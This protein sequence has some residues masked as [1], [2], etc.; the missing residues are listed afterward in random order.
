VLDESEFELKWGIWVKTKERRYAPSTYKIVN[1]IR[2]IPSG[3]VD[4]Y[5]RVAQRA[6]LYKGA[7]QVVRILST[8][9]D[10][11]KLPWH[12]VLNKQGML[13]LKGESFQVQE[14]LLK[15]EGVVIE[16]GV[17]DLTIFLYKDKHD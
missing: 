10:L 1:A 7:R 16:H 13:A 5:G 8:L 11:E 4:T 15:S 9:G 2:E 3:K 6:G 17:V 12:R 14:A